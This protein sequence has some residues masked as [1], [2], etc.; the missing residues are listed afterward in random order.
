MEKSDLR[1]MRMDN[2]IPF[3]ILTWTV[4]THKINSNTFQGEA[5]LE[6]PYGK[7][8]ATLAAKD[9]KLHMFKNS[10][11]RVKAISAEYNEEEQEWQAQKL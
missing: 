7:Y 11:W 1:Q 4:E 5:V 6:D 10:A 8:I 3:K 9:I 2:E